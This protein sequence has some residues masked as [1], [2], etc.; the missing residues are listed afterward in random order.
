MAGIE[1]HMLERAVESMLFL[2]NYWTD[3]GF[4]SGGAGF[5]SGGVNYHEAYYIQN[6]KRFEQDTYNIGRYLHTLKSVN[7]INEDMLSH[8]R[9][10]GDPVHLFIES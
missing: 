10:S 7:R 3:A 8:L 9:Y 4:Y 2:L 5:Y 6:G 1:L